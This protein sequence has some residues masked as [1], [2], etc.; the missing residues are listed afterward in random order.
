MV[1][2]RLS[3]PHLRRSFVLPFPP[4]PLPIFATCPFCQ[5]RATGAL[6]LTCLASLSLVSVVAA[7]YT[8]NGVLRKQR[9]RFVAPPPCLVLAL[10]QCQSADSSRA[11]ESGGVTAA[12]SL[13]LSPLC[14]LHACGSRHDEHELRPHLCVNVVCRGHGWVMM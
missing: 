4:L 10:L 11:D 9:L 2:W 6:L 5:S 1:G 13:Q 8:G 7:H 3:A 14:A 12:L